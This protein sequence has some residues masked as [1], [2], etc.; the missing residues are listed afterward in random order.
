MLNNPADEFF[1]AGQQIIAA[2]AADLS[3]E[4]NRQLNRL[5]G[6]PFQAA[7]GV[8]YDRNGLTTAPF[9]TL[10]FTRVQGTEITEGQPVSIVA[11]TLACAIDVSRTMDLDGLRR[12][13]ER[14][15]QTKTLKKLPPAHDVTHTTI[16]DPL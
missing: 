12:A 7:S 15:V 13:Y 2:P 8:A 11:D 16:R 1:H 6:W 14:V 10:I 5:L 4:L 9:G 3:D